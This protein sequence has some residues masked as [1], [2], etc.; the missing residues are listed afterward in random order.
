MSYK[1][2]RPNDIVHSTIVAHP[3]LNFF[4]NSGSLYINRESSEV[5]GHSNN[6]KHINQGEISL[7]ELNINR[8]ADSL[9][10]RFIE[11]SSTRYAFRTIS[12]SQF[13]DTSQLAFGSV[14]VSYTHLTQPPICS[15]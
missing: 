6:V 12:T 9:V 3:D 14:T 11:K 13:D 4:V 8:P 7:D 15:E 10:Y 1:K 2:F 5:G